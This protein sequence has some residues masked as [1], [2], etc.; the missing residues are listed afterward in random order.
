MRNQRWTHCNLGP[1]PVNTD[2]SLLLSMSEAKSQSQSQEQRV[3]WAWVCPGLGHPGSFEDYKS[4]VMWLQSFFSCSLSI[5][6]Q[7]LRAL[8]L[9]ESP[10]A[11]AYALSLALNVRFI[12]GSWISGFSEPETPFFSL[13][14][15]QMVRGGGS[16]WTCWNAAPHHSKNFVP[17]SYRIESPPRL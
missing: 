9:N 13:T 7:F 16:W 10:E 3:L 8:L 5:C 4:H 11:A 6:S 15:G 17:S 12:L 14:S 2:P 1:D